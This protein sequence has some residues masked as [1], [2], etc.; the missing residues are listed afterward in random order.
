MR[1][2]QRAP[3]KLNRGLNDS[4]DTRAEEAS[5]RQL[6]SFFLRPLVE[7]GDG[8]YAKSASRRDPMAEDNNS[9]SDSWS[10]YVMTTGVVIGVMIGIAT[11]DLPI[12]IGLGVAAG[13]LLGLFHRSRK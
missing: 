5:T 7:C 8:S 10:P 3:V 1:E 13:A 6:R 12:W 4:N 11:D 2:V 9:T